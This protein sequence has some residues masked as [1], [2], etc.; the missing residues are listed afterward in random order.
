MDTRNLF[1]VLIFLTCLLLVLV[2]GYIV[3]HH[4][5][6]NRKPQADVENNPPPQQQSR[7]GILREH[8]DEE[9]RLSHLTTV[10][11]SIELLPGI[12][13][14]TSSDRA[15]DWLERRDSRIIDGDLASKTY[16]MVAVNDTTDEKDQKAS[17]WN[18]RAEKKDIA[19]ISDQE[20]LEQGRKKDK[21]ASRKG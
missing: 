4:Y 20:K 11:P 21:D 2:M 15:E 18:W 17:K 5:R 13:T 12:R 19:K 3:N 10:A 1:I 14:S 9:Q 7:P 6:R 8:Y 16:K